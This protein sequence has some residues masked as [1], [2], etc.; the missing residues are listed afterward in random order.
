M[1]P[2]NSHRNDRPRD[3]DSRNGPKGKRPFR[4]R[5][6]D[7]KDFRKDDKRSFERKG[8]R[9]DDRG[10]SQ[11]RE[12]KPFERRERREPCEKTERPWITIPDDV[13]SILFKGVDFQMKGDDVKAMILFLHGSVLM[14]KGCENNA[15]RILDK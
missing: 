1:T 14:S 3:R 11:N 5:S 8:P 12:R 4:G 2:E 9:R 13:Q 15:S 10:H 6:D 7:R